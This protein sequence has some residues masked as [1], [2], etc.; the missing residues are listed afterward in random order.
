MAS[1]SITT[2]YRPVGP[3]ELALV[4][5]SGWRRFP[6][7]LPHQPI[8]YPVLDYEYAVEIARDWNT[9]ES[10]EG[11]VLRFEVS[12][13]LMSDPGVPERMAHL[14]K[15]SRLDPQSRQVRFVLAT[16]GGRTRREYWIPAESLDELND[17]IMGA[18]IRAILNARRKP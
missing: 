15:A 7:R 5:A 14:E 4:A 13:A 16:A 6:P 12:L 11:H 17:R 9:K 3:E 10:G 2:L 8:F 18:H 1:I